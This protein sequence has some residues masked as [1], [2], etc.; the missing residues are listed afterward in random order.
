MP[1]LICVRGDD[2][3]SDTRGFLGVN[4]DPSDKCCNRDS[5]F[6]ITRNKERSTPR[7]A[8]RLHV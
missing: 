1:C 5:I 3:Q 6:L 7:A 8:S 4:Q 2:H